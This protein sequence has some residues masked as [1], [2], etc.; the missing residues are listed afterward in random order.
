VVRAQ[1]KPG[2]QAKEKLHDEAGWS[3]VFGK[4]SR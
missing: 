3:A 4:M 2:K 1:G